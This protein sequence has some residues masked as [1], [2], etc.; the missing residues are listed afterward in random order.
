MQ[1]SGSTPRRYQ[2]LAAGLEISTGF[3]TSVAG[4]VIVIASIPANHASF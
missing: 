3:L 4:S 2:D 1:L